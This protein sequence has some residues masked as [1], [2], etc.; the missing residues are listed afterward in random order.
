MKTFAMTLG[1]LDYEN[2]FVL[3]KTKQHYP[4]AVNIVF[5][6][7]S[8]A[9]P[10]ILMNMLIGLAVGDI[11]KIQQKSVMARYVMQVEL[12]LEIEESLPQWILRRVQVDKHEEFPNRKSKLSTKIYEKFIGFGKAESMGDDDGVPPAMAQIIDKI[13]EQESKIEDIHEMLKEQSKILKAIGQREGIE[14][15]GNRKSIFGF[16]WFSKKR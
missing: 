16:G 1:E 3:P 11:D 5:V 14:E 15:A 7:F 2:D 12:L 4:E 6:L 10:I 8:L 9:M 13:F